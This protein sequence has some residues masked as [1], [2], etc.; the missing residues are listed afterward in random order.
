MFSVIQLF[1]ETSQSYIFSTCVH[2]C[3]SFAASVAFRP[4][5]DK[6]LVHLNYSIKLNH[7]AQQVL[8]FFHQ[9]DFPNISMTNTLVLF[10][11]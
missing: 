2:A 1:R 4:E 8:V 3:P 6:V 5:T 10:L 11:N 7:A 9:H